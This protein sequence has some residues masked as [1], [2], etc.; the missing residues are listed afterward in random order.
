[1]LGNDLGGSVKGDPYV[2]A[3]ATLLGG[4]GTILTI[5]FDKTGKGEAKG[6]CLIRRSSP[7]PT[8]QRYRRSSAGR[9][10]KKQEFQHGSQGRSSSPASAH[11][12]ERTGPTSQA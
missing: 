2:P 12:A 3:L 1:M 5:T 6:Y 4:S 11:R 7:A 10:G 8:A 9:S